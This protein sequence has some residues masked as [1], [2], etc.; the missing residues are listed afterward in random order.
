[1]QGQHHT[2]YRGALPRWQRMLLKGEGKRRR[3]GIQMLGGEVAH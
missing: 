2:R 1:M 3:L